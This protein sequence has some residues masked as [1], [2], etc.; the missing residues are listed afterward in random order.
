MILISSFL[1]SCSQDDGLGPGYKWELFENAPNWNLA[2]AIKQQDTAAIF[3]IVKQKKIDLNLQEPTFGR[4]LLILAVGN[5][6]FYST[7]AL[8]IAGADLG[9]RDSSGDAGNS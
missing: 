7:Q 1:S 4:T 5:D 6:K 3:E 9:I 8:I 2:K